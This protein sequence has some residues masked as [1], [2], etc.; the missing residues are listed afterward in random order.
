[1]SQSHWLERAVDA[2]DVALLLVGTD[3]KVVY[4]NAAAYRLY[5]IGAGVLPGTGIERLVVPERRGELRN[6]E[7]VLAGGGAR[8]VRSMLRRDDGSRVD[9]T[10][11]L[12]PCFDE[13]ANVSGVSVRYYDAPHTSVRPGLSTSKPPLG[14]NAPSGFASSVEP[15]RAASFSA[16]PVLTPAG[17]LPLLLPDSSRSQS[18]LAPARPP[19]EQR[20]RLSKLLKNLEWLDERLSTPASVAPLD[21]ARERARA[22]LVIGESLGLCEESLN[23]LEGSA[24]IP[25]APRMPRM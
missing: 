11:V 17:P 16:P 1:M 9:V 21:D 15:P 24:E 6:I 2:L 20:E 12:E 22:M 23:A 19:N 8:K 3:R 4:A 10:M 13:Q 18:R 25:P 7:D 5:G 14:M